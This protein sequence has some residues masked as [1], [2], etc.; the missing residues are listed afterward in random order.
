[1]GIPVLLDMSFYI[2]SYNTSRNELVVM[3]FP[4]S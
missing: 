3:R 2:L 4:Q 1:M